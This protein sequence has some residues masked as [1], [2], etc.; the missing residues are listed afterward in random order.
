MM[1]TWS[2][3]APWSIVLLQ[4]APSWAKSAERIEG[5]IIAFGAMV[6]M[7]VYV[8]FCLSLLMSGRSL[9]MKYLSE[10]RVY[11]SVFLTFKESE[12]KTRRMLNLIEEVSS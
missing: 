7:C 3:S 4:S 1:S 11:V 5:A 8:C 9:C 6:C 12:T 2:Q 10:R